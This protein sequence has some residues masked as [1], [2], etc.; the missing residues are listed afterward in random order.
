[1]SPRKLE[2]HKVT[3]NPVFPLPET[4]NNFKYAVDFRLIL[5][6]WNLTGIASLTLG[7]LQIPE[8]V[9]LSLGR[10]DRRTRIP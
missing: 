7:L 3:G 2:D 10:A 9:R 6:A 8:K 5:G 1:M 4:V